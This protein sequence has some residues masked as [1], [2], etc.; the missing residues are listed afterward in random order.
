M[1][2]ELIILY[3]DITCVY[4]KTFI[5]SWMLAQNILQGKL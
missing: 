2:I 4:R 3:E 1:Y 5:H